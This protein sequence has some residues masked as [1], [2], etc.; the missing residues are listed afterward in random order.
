MDQGE[1][2]P[3]GRPEHA[4]EL[5]PLRATDGGAARR[6]R[7]LNRARSLWL[8]AYLAGPGLSELRVGTIDWQR[9]PP[10]V[11]EPCASRAALQAA[12]AAVGWR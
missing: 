3:A 6:V 12:F 8:V 5:Q 4:L 11:I 7:V 10:A 1:D 2:A 9:A